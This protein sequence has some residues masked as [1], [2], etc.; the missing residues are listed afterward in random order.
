MK[1]LLTYKVS[2]DHLELFFAAVRQASGWNNNPTTRQFKSTYKQLI[3]RH[4]IKGGVGNCIAQDNT[5]ILNNVEDQCRV[6][7]CETGTLNISIMR[8]YDLDQ[9]SQE[10]GNNLPDL[11]ADVT[12][13]IQLSEYKEEAISY[14]AGFVSKM[15]DKQIACPTCTDALTVPKETATMSFVVWKSN[16]GLKIPSKS[17]LRVCHET[18]KCLMRML[19]STSGNLPHC[20]SGLTDAIAITVLSACIGLNIFQDLNEHMYECTVTNNHIGS[21]IKCSSRCYTK[22]R[23]HHLAKKYSEKIQGEKLRKNL[24]KLILFKNQ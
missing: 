15:V 9:H 22:I 21:L 4:N 10:Q 17:L 12:N 13:A 1:Y 16:G 7:S 8:R 14:I 6:N 11:P 20:S 3:M 5:R 19:H 2:Q 24:S 18:E 23:M